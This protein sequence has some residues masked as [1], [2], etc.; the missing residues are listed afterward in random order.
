MEALRSGYTEVWISRPVLPLVT[1]A[2]RVRAIADTGLDLAGLPGMPLPAALVDF[3]RIH[4]WYGTG[5]EEFRAAVAHLPFVF[6]PAL[7]TTP[8]TLVPRIPIRGPHHGAIVLHPFSGSA[9]K[10]WPLEN[11]QALA[12]RLPGVR[13]TAGPEEPLAEA[14][15]FDSLADLAAWLSGARLY[16]GN[17]SGITHLAAA[18]GTPVLA[19]FGPSDPQVWCP[20][21]GHVR[22]VPFGPVDSIARAAYEMLDCFRL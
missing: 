10:N 20:A 5:R 11:F 12:A 8:P 18:V 6:H 9:R 22:W 13:W 17:D 16:I 2:D 1:F 14:T 19:L 7:P 4:S 3:D 15:R 21:G